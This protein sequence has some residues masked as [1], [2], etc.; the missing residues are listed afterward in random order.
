MMW[1]A[2]LL[3][4]RLGAATALALIPHGRAVR[5]ELDPCRL[6]IVVGS[7]LQAGAQPGGVEYLLEATHC[8]RSGFAPE[9]LSLLRAVAR[10]DVSLTAGLAQAATLDARYQIRSLDSVIVVRPRKAWADPQDF[11]N[12]RIER[13]ELLDTD[14]RGALVT[15]VSMVG[16]ANR[17]I[18]RVASAT[19]QM[20]RRFSLELGDPTVQTALNRIVYEHGAS[21]WRVEYCAASQ[22]PEF[23]QIR[24]STFDTGSESTGI[25]RRDAD[26]ILHEG[27]ARGRR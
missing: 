8:E 10:R 5:A 14:L 6:P 20:L 3:I 19:P 11:L 7:L 22:L 25:I 9:D 17:S 18:E 12:Q 2:R 16:R 15:I 26:G 21:V 1:Q 27:C 13:V 23:S 4:T 24:I